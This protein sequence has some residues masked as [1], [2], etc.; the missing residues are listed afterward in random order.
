MSR[1][2]IY[3]DKMALLVR[4][5][6]IVAIFSLVYSLVSVYIVFQP[7]VYIMAGNGLLLLVNLVYFKRT[8]NFA[9]T[10]HLFLLSNCFVAVMGSSYFSGGL[11]SPV[12]P[13]FALV[14]VTATLLFGFNRSTY[15][16]LGLAVACIAAL[17]AVSFSDDGAP[18]LFD[19]RYAVFFNAMCLVGSAVLLAMLTQL[20]EAAKNNALLVS[21]Q[22]NSDLEVAIRRLQE[23]REQL[24]QQEKLASLG[25]LVAGV[26]HELNTP[27]GNAITTASALT[28]ASAELKKNIERGDLRKSALLEFLTNNEAMNQLITR[29]CE[30][31]GRLINSFKQVAVDQTA[32]QR[33]TFELLSLLEDNV[34]ALRPSVSHAKVS[35][36]LDVPHGIVCDSYPG[37]LGQ[38]IVNIVQNAIVHAFSGRDGGTVLIVAKCPSAES[39][40]ILVE[41]NGSGMDAHVMA[42]IFDPFFTTRLGQGGSGLGLSVSQNITTG[43]LGGTL[44]V[45]SIVGEG[46]RFVLT[47]PMSAP[48]RAPAA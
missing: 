9:L 4:F 44:Q 29:S 14:P 18:V 46:S 2:P 42:H 8:L 11:Y 32:E 47:M 22:K 3:A 25:S 34:G 33:R 31:A 5:H 26:A 7:G 10:A 37:P 43:V 28:Y 40:E 15:V 12:A 21:D 20:F 45:R 6:W 13:W 38:V 35:I 39:V 1:V 41:D 48:V 17:I 30:R 27:I 16:W 23:T 36:E 24:V 19:A